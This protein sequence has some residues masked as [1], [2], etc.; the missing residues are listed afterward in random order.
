MK[1][2]YEVINEKLVITAK[3]DKKEIKLIKNTIYKELQKNNTT[4]KFYRDDYWAGVDKVREDVMNALHSLYNKTKHDYTCEI[5]AKNGG[6]RKNNDGTQWKEYEV[7]IYLNKKEEPFM[8]G[9][10]NC[11]AA[12]TIEDPFSMYDMSFIIN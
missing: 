7:S 10:L 4:G 9:I 6:Y 1:S 11:H 12:G 2:L 3:V 8:T 5:T